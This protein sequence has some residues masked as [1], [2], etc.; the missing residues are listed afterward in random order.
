MEGALSF[1][2]IEMT[3][4]DDQFPAPLDESMPEE[5]SS[6]S[7]ATIWTS[8]LD[9]VCLYLSLVIVSMLAAAPVAL[10]VPLAKPVGGDSL[11]QTAALLYIFALA[12]VIFS[13]AFRAIDGSAP[14]WGRRLWRNRQIPDS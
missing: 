11:A 6:A 12:P 3:S 8:W 10:L 4:N 13:K 7:V 2:N 9:G 5:S 1:A 14:V